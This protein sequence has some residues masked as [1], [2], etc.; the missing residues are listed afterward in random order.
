MFSSFCAVYTVG[1]QTVPYVC[2]EKTI[3]LKER[4]REW[5]KAQQISRRNTFEESE[6][7]RPCAARDVL[8][9]NI[10]QS[11]IVV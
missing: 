2:V 7:V 10:L 1:T 5:L 8:A 11:N 6:K 4:C 9:G 3:T